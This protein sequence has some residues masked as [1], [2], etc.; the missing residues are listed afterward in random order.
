MYGSLFSPHVLTSRPHGLQ[1]VRRRAD[2]AP[3]HARG[4]I[5]KVDR[6]IDAVLRHRFDNYIAEPPL[7]RLRHGRPIALAPAHGEGVADG[8]PGD[9]DAAPTR[10]KRPAFPGIGGELVPREPE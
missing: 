2:Q 5:M 10:R 3:G 4:H 1:R 6:T 9:I 8:P 7:L